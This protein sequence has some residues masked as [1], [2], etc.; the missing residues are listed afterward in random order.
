ME[1]IPAIDLREGR[2]VRL[3][4]GDFSRATVYAGDPVAVARW[5]E[6]QGAPRLHIVDL[7]GAERGRPLQLRLVERIAAAVGIPLQ[8]GGG[9]RDMASLRSALEA[10]AERVV[11][12]TAVLEE[13]CLVASAVARFGPQRVVVAVDARR[14][15]VAL[16]GW[17][18]QSSTTATDLVRRVRGMGVVRFL[19]TDILRD[20]TM[21]GPNFRGV[22]A[23]ARLGVAVLASGGI[24]TLDHLLGLARCGAEGAVVGRALY[25]GA[26]TL[27][28]ALEALASPGRIGGDSPRKEP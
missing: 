27:P 22:R 24:A 2:C 23:L 21:R 9:L 18:D 7:D 14:G 10:G 8:V 13:P 25:E 4:Q 3:Y 20:G 1:V 26:F 17:R 5:W 15:R 6:E 28:Q 16:R 12:G 11:L 19:Y